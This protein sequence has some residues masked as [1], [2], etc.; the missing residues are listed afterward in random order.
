MPTC[1]PRGKCEQMPRRGS[2]QPLVVTY[3]P[4]ET[5]F[6]LRTYPRISMLRSPT[7]GVRMPGAGVSPSTWA[8]MLV[9]LSLIRRTRAEW[10][11]TAT[12]SPTSQPLP[13]VTGSWT[14]TPLAAPAPMLTLEL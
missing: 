3:C 12:T 10:D 5:G 4:V 13:V 1:R 7:D 14:C 8:E 9:P 6:D 2:H 11:V